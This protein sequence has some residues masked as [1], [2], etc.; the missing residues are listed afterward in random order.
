MGWKHSEDPPV[1]SQGISNQTY[2]VLIFWEGQKDFVAF[3]K[4]QN[5]KANFGWKG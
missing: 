3:L 2:K 1:L 4:Y 5:F